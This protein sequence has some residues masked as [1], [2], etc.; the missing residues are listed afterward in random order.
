MEVKAEFSKFYDVEADALV[1][2]IYEGETIEEPALRD[3]NERAGGM[4]A[5][6]IGSDEMRGKHGDTV[7]V[8]H[9]GEIRARRLLLVGG[10]KRDDFSFDS[11][12]KITASAA[13][14]LRS[15][16]IRSMAILRRSRLDLQGSAQAAVEG[17]LT[18]LFEPDMY[19]TQEKEQRRIEQLVLVAA[20]AGT[21]KQLAQGVER[22]RIIGETVNFAREL[23]NEPSS[24]LTPTEL[25]ERSK[26]TGTRFGLEVDVLDEPR[27][28]ELGMGALLAVARGSDEPARLTVLRYSPDDSEESPDARPITGE[29]IAIVGKGVT[30]DSGG[31][32]IKPSEGMEKMKYDMSGA[33]STLAAMRAI[34][35]LK[36]RVNVIGLMPSTENMPSGRA[37]K[38][39]DIVRSMSGKTIEVVNTDAEG[40]LILADAITYARK[41]GATR[42]IDL[43]TLTGAVSV[44]LGAFNVAILGNDQSFIEEMRQAAREVGERLWP[45]PMDDE[46][47]EMINSDIADIKNSAG[48]YGGTITAAWFLREFAEEMPWVHLDIAGAAWEAER[49]PHTAKGPTGVAIRTLI[50]YV[51]SHAATT[52]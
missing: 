22:G 52:K 5:E 34:A 30:F 37:Y 46:Y 13:R 17:V 18:G 26:E 24:T 38:P 35:Q 20:N 15:K 12:R 44:A 3:L 10:G 33:A 36:P 19:K 39:G 14:S 43:A 49:K 28:K 42:I 25:A 29:T 6:L 23:I 9:P 27:M 48:R 2:I 4:L 31:I 47:R 45:L 11:V 21:E 40:R 51:C 41:L 16:G 50:N 8:H 1:V 32:S 7:Y